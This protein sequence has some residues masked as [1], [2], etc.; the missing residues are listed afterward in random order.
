MN[1]AVKVPCA[2]IWPEKSKRECSKW[3]IV[4]C[5]AWYAI[6]W[7]KV[8]KVCQKKQKFEHCIWFFSREFTQL[9]GSVHICFVEVWWLFQFSFDCD[10]TTMKSPRDSK[11]NAFH[12]QIR[13][14]GR[15]PPPGT[16]GRHPSPLPPC[17][18]IRATSGQYTSYWNAY[19]F[20]CN[21]QQ[22]T[23]QIIGFHSKIRGWRPLRLVNPGSATTFQQWFCFP[24]SV[25]YKMDITLCM[26]ELLKSMYLYLFSTYLHMTS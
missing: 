14:R 5:H 15:H 3:P 19:S 7:F 10:D 2:Q 1:S 4:I 23:C 17:W 24:L 25:I 16:R 20:S 18:E 8:V 11:K 13:T 12:W 21:F 9:S 26:K 6:R 22:K